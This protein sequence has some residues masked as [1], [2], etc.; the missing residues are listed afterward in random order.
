MSSLP[1][2]L[3]V[4]W[5]WEMRQSQAKLTPAFVEVL[6]ENHNPRDLDEYLQVL[7]D[8]NVPV[9]THGVSLSL[10]SA[11]PP[12]PDTLNM[13]NAVAE[14]CDS[15]VISEHIALV[16]AQ[17]LDGYASPHARVLEAGHLLPVP[18]TSDQLAVMVDNV[19]RAQ[20]VLQRP[21]ALEPIATLV[22]W[23]DPQM[24][25]GEFVTALL[26][27]TGAGLVLD[28]ANVWANATNH[29]R[30]PLTDVLAMPLERIAY[31]HI[32]GGSWRGDMYH[33][34]HASPVVQQVMTLAHEVVERTGPVPL[35]LERDSAFP[36][37]DEMFAELN[38]LAD[39][40]GLDRITP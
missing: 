9:V 15:P 33:D 31:C 2:G 39:I 17:E 30:D 40:A 24:P 20:D 32:A 36:P 16:R 22:E 25:E 8:S 1:A 7:V 12:D 11:E 10:G 29:G 5:R 23:P 27:E 35:M 3:G 21:L 38:A 14:A 4:G 34:T 26:D 13:L 6:A 18:L 28:I 37:E 19:H